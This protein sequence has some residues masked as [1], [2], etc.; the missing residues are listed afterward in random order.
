MAKIEIDS[1]LCK[2][3]GL[4]FDVCPLGLLRMG[5]KL[6]ATGAHYAVQSEPEKCI[7]CK[8]CAIMCPDI[9]IS[10]YK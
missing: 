1:S 2:A 5:D 3:C 9:A 8:M 7:G 4:C 10:V 6:N